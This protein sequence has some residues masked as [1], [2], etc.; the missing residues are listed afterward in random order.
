MLC[1]Y[2]INS[3]GEANNDNNAIGCNSTFEVI[4]LCTDNVMDND[5]NQQITIY[6]NPARNEIF[7]SNTTGN[8]K[9]KVSIFNQLVK[10]VLTKNANTGHTDISLLNQGIYIIEVISKNIV[11]RQLLVVK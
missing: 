8:T 1:D 6:P 2:L 10:L 9:F 3:S 4:E 11:S 5:N 7:I